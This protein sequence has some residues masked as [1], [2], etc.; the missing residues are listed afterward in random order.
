M[1]SANIKL[2]VVTYVVT[3]VPLSVDLFLQSLVL[4]CI[5]KFSKPNMKLYIYTYVCMF[6]CECFVYMVCIT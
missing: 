3:T 5:L 1:D 6:R 4:C 2:E